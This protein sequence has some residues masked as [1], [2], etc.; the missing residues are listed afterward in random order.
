MIDFADTNELK[1][2]IKVFGVGGGGGNALNNMIQQNLG[3][4]MFYAANTDAQALNSNLAP[5][6][7]QLGGRLTGGLGA[8]GNPD[9]GYNAALEDQ[10]ALAELMSDADMVFV[11]AGMGGGTGTGGAPV[12][13]HL[14]REAGALTVG[15]VT[16][17]FTFEGRKRGRNAELGLDALSR[18]VDTLIVIPNDRLL[19]VADRKMTMIDAF[20]V[21]DQVLFDA[22]KSISDII[23]TPGLINVDFAD[24]K[25]IMSGKGRALMGTGYASG[26]NRAVEAA[27]M[28]ISSPLLEDAAIDGATGILINITGGADM[29]LYEVNE[30]A[31]LIEEAA[32]ENANIIWGSVID[33]SLADQIKITV[34]ATGFDPSAGARDD[35]ERTA[36]SEREQVSQLL[37]GRER[38]PIPALVMEPEPELEEVLPPRQPVVTTALPQTPPMAPPTPTPV[39][40]TERRETR[41]PVPYNPFQEPTRSEYD[42]PTF[43]RRPRQAPTMVRQF[44][45]QP[46]MPARFGGSSDDDPKLPL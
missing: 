30:A 13:A 26:E 45:P 31:T 34:V 11:T 39:R 17:P 10:S 15:V 43:T 21:A 9:K 27:K 22:V 24:V 2:R 7:M 20:R 37:A 32:D 44:S 35:D 5:V 4:V 25:A 16:R 42:S 3:G 40:T 12:V 8:G 18:E 41:R 38:R 14:A 6:K 36:R 1:A 28:A 19:D 33:E 29:T 23:V 46:A